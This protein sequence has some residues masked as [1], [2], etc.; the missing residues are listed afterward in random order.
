MLDAIK[1]L[2]GGK[3]KRI[4]EQLDALEAAISRAQVEKEL[5][6][7]LAAFDAFPGQ[8]ASMR[9]FNAGLSFVASSQ[10]ACA[11]ETRSVSSSGALLVRP[12][13]G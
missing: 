9:R 3:G 6:R 11:C 8:A 10:I 2:A 1:N 5:R 12:P 13:C 7:Q 4:E